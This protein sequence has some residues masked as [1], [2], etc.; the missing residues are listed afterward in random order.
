MK[1]RIL[2]VDDQSGFT[3]IIKLTLEKAGDYEVLEKNSSAGV[4][5]AAIE[6]DPHAIL[7]DVIMPGS[8]GGDVVGLLQEN[9]RTKAIPVIFI[10]A[11]VRKQEIDAQGGIIG[12][13]PFLPKP[14]A[15]K[16]LIECIEKHAR[17]VAEA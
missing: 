5:T 2:I 1:K 10:T 8:D 6:F 3:R 16:E 11:T 7:L 14:V 13:Y 4:V 17:P 9:P 12:G 15:A